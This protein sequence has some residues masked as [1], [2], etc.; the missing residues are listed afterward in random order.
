MSQFVAVTNPPLATVDTVITTFN[1]V[2]RWTG[3]TQSL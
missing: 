2:P 3:I 1:Y